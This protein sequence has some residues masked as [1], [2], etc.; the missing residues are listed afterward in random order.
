MNWKITK[1]QNF[2]MRKEIFYAKEHN[3]FLSLFVRIISVII[4]TILKRKCCK[5]VHRVN[6]KKIY[7]Q[8]EKLHSL[9]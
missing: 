2:G 7:R 1:N 5:E 9:L 4:I 3:S 8:G 6:W